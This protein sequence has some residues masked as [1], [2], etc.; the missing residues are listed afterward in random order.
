MMFEANNFNPVARVTPFSQFPEGM[1]LL[2]RPSTYPLIEHY[3]VLITG[4]LVR[5]LGI[6]SIAPVVIQQTLPRARVD[7]AEATGNWNM[8]G[9]VLPPLVPFAME[10]VSVAFR[11]PNY[12][13]FANN[14]EQFARFITVGQKTSTQ[15]WS[16]AFG[17]TL[18]AVAIIFLSRND[19]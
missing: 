14:C 15:L 1:Y 16:F 9:Q 2:K 10:R 4:D 13:L 12:D 6:N 7:L 19:N 18:A 17:G 5:E 11:D 3:G 8:V